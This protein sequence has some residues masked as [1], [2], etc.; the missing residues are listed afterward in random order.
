[1]ETYGDDRGARN[2]ITIW[3][4]RVACW[5]SEATC[6]RPRARARTHAQSLTQICNS[7]YVFDSNNGYVN[8]SQCYA[9]RTLPV[10]YILYKREY[11]NC[12]VGGFCDHC[13]CVGK[14]S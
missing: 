12:V 11:G 7:R 9:I 13:A 14:H 6:T 3:C 1:M 2:D 4:I 5:I 10:L 8:P